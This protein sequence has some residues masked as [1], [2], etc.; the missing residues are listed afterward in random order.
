MTILGTLES[1]DYIHTSGNMANGEHPYVGAVACSFVPLGTQIYI[2]G[3]GY[4]VVKNR[5]GWGSQ[6][7]IFLILKVNV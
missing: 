6:L 3:L 4:Y 7:D 5:I 1:T 2:E